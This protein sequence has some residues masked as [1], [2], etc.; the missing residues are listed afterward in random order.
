MDNK[1]DAAVVKS[2]EELG[3]WKTP[4]PSTLPDDLTDLQSQLDAYEEEF[5]KMT[6]ENL[7]KYLVT[8][9]ER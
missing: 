7:Q 3:L 8:Q 4:D 2:L 5:G 9:R 1:K 6:P